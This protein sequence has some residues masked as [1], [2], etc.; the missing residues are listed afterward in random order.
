MNILYIL[1]IYKPYPY[2]IYSALLELMFAEYIGLVLHLYNAYS[3]AINIW[4]TFIIGNNKLNKISLAISYN[5]ILQKG[6]FSECL[7]KNK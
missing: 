1:F 5:L 3:L 2:Y 7:R 6:V 4:M